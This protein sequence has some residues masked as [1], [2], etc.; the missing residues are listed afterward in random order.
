[1]K[2]RL[3]IC[4]A[5]LVLLSFIGTALCFSRY[6]AI[7]YGSDK[8]NAAQ[9]VIEYV[10]V[11]AALNGVSLPDIT[12]GINVSDVKP[13]DVL[14]CNFEIRNYKGT[15][16]N[17][18]L[19]KYHINVSFSP[20]QEA[21]PFSYTLT[22]ADSYPSAGDDWSY[23][24]YGSAQTHSYTLKVIWQAADTDEKYLNRQQSVRIAVDC[25]QVNQLP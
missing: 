21:I 13:G 17:E 9:A 4:V 18:V 23:L 11:N 12:S 14:I 19:L 1:M 16:M 7:D 5:Y 8:T 20:E 6:E 10:P 22:P 24:N 2:Y 3:L 25:Q 15:T